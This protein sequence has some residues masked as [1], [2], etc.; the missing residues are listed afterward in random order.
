MRSPKKITEMYAYVVTQPDGGEGI[1]AFAGPEGVLMPMVAADKERFDCLRPIA[2]NI[3]NMTGQ[4]LRLLK[5]S[6]IEQIDVV[7]SQ[8]K[9][10]RSN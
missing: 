5:F 8:T 2:Q 3:A 6:V 1:P 9:Q 4:E 10:A 7:R